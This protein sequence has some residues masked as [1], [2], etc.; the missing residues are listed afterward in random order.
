MNLPVSGDDNGNEKKYVDA[1]LMLK[2]PDFHMAQMA[3]YSA[4]NKVTFLPDGVPQL[5]K[6]QVKLTVFWQI[7]LYYY[8]IFPLK[9]NRFLG[10]EST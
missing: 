8:A 7:F 4:L 3:W 10:S 2:L 5:E 9:W 1:F 6:L